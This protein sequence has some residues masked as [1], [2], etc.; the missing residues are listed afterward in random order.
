[1]IKLYAPVF[2]GMRIEN[3]KLRHSNWPE[4]RKRV[5]SQG[6]HFVL[7]RPEWLEFFVPVNEPVQK[8]PWIA[9][10]QISVNTRRFRTY[11]RISGVPAKKRK[12]AGKRIRRKKKEKNIRFVLLLH[13]IYSSSSPNL[14]FLF[15]LRLVWFR[16]VC[17]FCI[18]F[19]LFAFLL[20]GLC[21]STWKAML[22]MCHSPQVIAS[23]PQNII[24]IIYIVWLI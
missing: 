10:L 9:P 12:P 22:Y 18:I 5:V 23:S 7:F 13:Q 21:S 19:F 17:L 15:L 4:K 11:R 6:G 20:C 24:Y 3:V 16:S 2:L 14:F 8:H 1:M